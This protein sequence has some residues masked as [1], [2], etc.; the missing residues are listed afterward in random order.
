M[1][2]LGLFPLGI[3]LFPESVI[4][5]HIFEE[6]YKL[7]INQCYSENTRFGINLMSDEKI[8]NVGCSAEVSDVMKKYSDGKLDVIAVGDKRYKLNNFT[9]GQKPYYIGDVEYFE[10][11]ET[12][13]DS[14]LLNKCINFYNQI[15]H[16][17]STI[18]VKPIKYNDLNTLKPS[19]LIA[20]KSGLALLQKQQ[21]LEMTSENKRLEFLFNHLSGLFPVIDEAETITKII[22]YDGY[23]K[24]RFFNK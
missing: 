8:H 22:K 16:K 9:E 18:K 15:A 4:P 3:V 20:Q 21:M 13:I 7:L 17:I 2:K 24:P 14:D 23:I 19:F 1:D 6:R 10:D 12:E 11:E 5:L